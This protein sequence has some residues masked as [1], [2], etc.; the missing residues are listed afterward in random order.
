MNKRDQAKII[1]EAM[2]KSGIKVDWNMEGAIIDGLNEI[3]I[4]KETKSIELTYDERKFME[5]VYV[6]HIRRLETLIDTEFK[7]E[8]DMQASCQNKIE[9]IRRLLWKL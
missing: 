1:L 2:D 8:P 7:N 9:K 4:R 6:D 5:Q 3:D